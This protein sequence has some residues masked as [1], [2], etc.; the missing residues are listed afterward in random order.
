[1]S[2]EQS[3]LNRVELIYAGRRFSNKKIVHYYAR[4]SDV[5]PTEIANFEYIVFNKKDTVCSVGSVVSVEQA[6]ERSFHLS[7]VQ[8]IGA[9]SNKELLTRWQALDSAV[10]AHQRAVKH[11]K[12]D[13][14]D[15]IDKSLEPILRALK[16]T[17]EAGK[18]AIIGLVNRR[19][20]R[21]LLFGVK[22]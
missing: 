21:A 1:L 6:T 7:T 17:D 20:M 9:T 18:T 12:E 19:I 10:H 2:E 15:M 13:I 8:Y 5:E 3:Q 14:P 11:A 22:K 16:D 4:R